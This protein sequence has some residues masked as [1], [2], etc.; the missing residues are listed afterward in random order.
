MSDVSSE[1]T[2]V[3][4]VRAPLLLEP[5]DRQ[6]ETLQACE[7]EGTIDELLLR[8]WPKE[9]A[10]SESSAHQEVLE[11]Y[12]R[13]SAWARERGV[14]IAPPFTERSSTSQITGETTELLVTPLLC[15]EVYAGD[16]LVGVYPHSAGEETYTANE[17]IAALR[18]GTVPTPLGKATEDVASVADDCPACGGELVD[19]QGL[20]A[21][22]DCG[23]IATMT[24]SGELA[25]RSE[26]SADDRSGTD[27]D[28]EAAVDN[29]D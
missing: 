20:F 10:R 9:V 15:L 24:P 3:C 22:S 1:T 11:L 6:V 2:V 23:W 14:S 29:I 18:T 27:T 17:V 7:S 19:G 25:D 5:I 8:S 16:D 28:L 12:D 26:A 13:F 21:C 4:H